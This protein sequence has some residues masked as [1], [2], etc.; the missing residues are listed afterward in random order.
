MKLG[1]SQFKNLDIKIMYEK[2][3]LFDNTLQI[4]QRIYGLVDISDVA[5]PKY[6]NSDCIPHLKNSSDVNIQ[7]WFDPIIVDMMYICINIMMAGK[8][9]MCTFYEDKSLLGTL[10]QRFL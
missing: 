5:P 7:S 9:F 4:R 8:C 1:I 6:Q 2:H 3:I 10:H